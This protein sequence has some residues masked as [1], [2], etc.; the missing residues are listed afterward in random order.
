MR[1]L[2]TTDSRRSERSNSRPSMRRFMLAVVA[3][4]ILAGN[5]QASP[6]MEPAENE[7]FEFSNRQ[8]IATVTT[9][10]DRSM[11]QVAEGIRLTIAVRV[12]AGATVAMPGSAVSL[13]PFEIIHVADKT[14]IPDGD[15][16]IWTRVYDLESLMS[17][18]HE[19]PKISMTLTDRRGESIQ[20]N[21]VNS[22]PVPIT[23][24]SFLE[25]KTD[26]TQFRDLKMVVDLPVISP[27]S[28]THWWVAGGFGLVIATLLLVATLRKHRQLD[29]HQ[30]AMAELE[31]LGFEQHLEEGRIPLFYSRLTDIV[32]NYVERRFDIAAPR[33]TTDEFLARIRDGETL[34]PAHGKLL[35]EFMAGADVVKFAS[36]CPESS[37]GTA[38]MESVRRFIIETAPENNQSEKIL[39]IQEA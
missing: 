15:D 1:H 25:G 39:T 36:Y 13:G 17:G 30:W 19:I 4:L 27:P 5:L 21:V 29:A 26:P 35:Q 18:T 34:Q 28:Y 32:R 37:A 24:S 20:R 33:L 23:V 31:T 10:V 8:G 9:T 6:A 3:T 12:P 16:R 7:P 38:V 22:Q 11:A 2:K 14:D